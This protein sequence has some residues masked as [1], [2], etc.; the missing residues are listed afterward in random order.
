MLGDVDDGV[1]TVI[2]K[3]FDQD[4]HVVEEGRRDICGVFDLLYLT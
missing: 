2:W 3:P 4:L 1:D